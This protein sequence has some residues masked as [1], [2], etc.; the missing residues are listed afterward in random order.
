MFQTRCSVQN[1]VASGKSV[2]ETRLY[3]AH[4][5]EL[6]CSRGR[7]SSCSQLPQTLPTKADVGPSIKR[8][9]S[10]LIA[11]DQEVEMEDSLLPTGISSE[12]LKQITNTRTSRTCHVALDVLYMYDYFATLDQ[13][14]EL[15]WF[16]PMSFMKLL[17]FLNRY[18]PIVC[19]II[20][21]SIYL[22][23]SPATLTASVRLCGQWF[24]FQAATTLAALGVIQAILVI[25]IWA[26]YARHKPLLIFLGVFGCFQLAATATI[27]GISVTQGVPLS[28]PEPGLFVCGITTPPYLAAYWIP[29]L[30]FE[31]TLFALT[32][33]KGVQNFRR[34]N[35]SVLSGQSGQ[36]ILNILVRDSVIYF[37]IIAAVY[38]GNAAVWFWADGTLYEASLVF[39]IIIP[40]MVASKLI[41][42]LRQT[43]HE[44]I[45]PTSDNHESIVFRTRAG[46]FSSGEQTHSTQGVGADQGQW[47]EWG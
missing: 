13:E 30:T 29:I 33:I 6:L 41:F 11:K 44:E 38:T 2:Q 4:R 36:A 32:L 23:E 18:L 31:F 42:S 40:P 35:V 10:D 21:A 24:K 16:K 46:T 37:F 34:T 19:G 20:S 9:N 26:I 39:G 1:E 27:M 47:E 22:D 17:F 5:W 14:V 7:L 3:Q 12:V 8:Q 25:R 28:E 45:V 43:F 15:V